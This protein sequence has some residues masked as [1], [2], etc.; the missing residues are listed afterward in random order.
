MVTREE[1]LAIAGS[2]ISGDRSK[3]YGDAKDN[4]ETIAAL[5]SSYLDHDFTVVDVANMMILMKIARSKTS[6]R[7]QDHWVDI[8]GYAALTGEIVSDG[9]DR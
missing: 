4:F 3:D 5:W 2:V 9:R 7:K 6:P 1:I 8:C